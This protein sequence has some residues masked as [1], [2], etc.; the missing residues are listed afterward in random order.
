LNV[1]EMSK[2]EL[3]RQIMAYDFSIIDLHLYLNTHPADQRAITLYNQYVQTVMMLR[4]QYQATYGPLLMNNFTS[5][6]PWQWIENA[7]PWERGG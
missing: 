4:N 1:K 7:F 5:R 6:C 3:L 2:N